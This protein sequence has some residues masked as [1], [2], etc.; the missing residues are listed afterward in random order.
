MLRATP[1]TFVLIDVMVSEVI[2][3]S[4]GFVEAMVA[5]G[6]SKLQDAEAVQGSYDLDDL[7]DEWKELLGQIDAAFLTVPPPPLFP[8]LHSPYWGTRGLDNVKS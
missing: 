2:C 5:K 4:D 8:L 1:W 7:D 6:G 3:N